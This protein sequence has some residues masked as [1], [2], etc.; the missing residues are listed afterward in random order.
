MR[1]QMQQ[2]R[3]ITKAELI[4]A[5]EDLNDDDQIAFASD[6]GDI[7]HTQQVHGIRGRIEEATLCESAYS[8]SGWAIRDE[9]D[10]EDEDENESKQ[11]VFVLR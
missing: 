3:T 9:D 8:D 6:Y 7:T 1:K 4:E 5:L 11:T 10:E 2:F